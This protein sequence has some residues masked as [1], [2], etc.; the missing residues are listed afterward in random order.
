MRPDPVEP[1]VPAAAAA[2]PPRLDYGQSPHPLRRKGV[3][4]A[5]WLAFAAA[6]LLPAWFGLAPIVEERWELLDFQRRWR[7]A[8]RV[9]T[10]HAYQETWRISKDGHARGRGSAH[11][12]AHYKLRQLYNLPVTS[13]RPNALATLFLHARRAPGAGERLVIVEFDRGPTDPAV[14][15][16]VTYALNWYTGTPAG[17]I[18]DP[19]NLASG[20]LALA[21]PPIPPVGETSFFNGQP[22]PKDPAR[23][24]V[25]YLIDGAQGVIDGRLL[26]DG[27][28][29]L[30][31]TSGPLA[32][33]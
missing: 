10:N 20:S 18:T 12:S 22:D 8:S 29:H 5:L 25:R 28:V 11:E 16:S 26:P 24:T 13:G 31:V 9:E 30:Q 17:W 15:A 33:R 19:S 4:V 7:T 27:K 2:E 6:I 23:F 1:A 32:P 3:K 14:G 21:R